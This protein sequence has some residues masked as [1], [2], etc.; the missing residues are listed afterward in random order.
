MID[1][2]DISDDLQMYDSQVGKGTNVLSVQLGS[3]EYSP[4]FGIDFEYFLSEEFEFQNEAFKAYMLQRLAESSVNV[5]DVTEQVE[6][7]FSTYAINLAGNT[8]TN[9]GLVR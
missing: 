9:P 1:I 2:I 5:S 7:L 6:T 4:N 3:L 8:E